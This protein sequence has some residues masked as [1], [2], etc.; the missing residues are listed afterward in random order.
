MSSAAVTPPS[1]PRQSIRK[2]LLGTGLG[3]ALEWYDWNVYTAM[4]AFLAAHLFD[5]SDPTSAVLSTL[6]VFA[7]GFLARPLGGFLF[8][9]VGDRKGRKFSLMLSVAAA[10]VGS[11]LIGL[12]PE[13]DT[14]GVVA[15]IWLLCARL[16]QG[17]AHGGELPSAQTYLV[18]E[19]PRERRGLW[20]SWIYVSGTAGNMIA[21]AVGALLATVLSRDQM[22]GFGWRIPF[23]LGAAFGLYA[24]YMR[25]GMI[26]SETF[27]ADVAQTDE[28]KIPLLKDI[29]AHW[30]QA[31]QVILMTSGGTVAY[32]AW[33]VNAPAYA[34]NQLKIPAAPA[35]WVGVAANLIFVALLPVYGW[36]SDRI[37][38]KKVALFSVLG[39][40]ALFIPMNAVLSNTPLSLFIAMGTMMITLSAYSAIAPAMYAEMFPTRVRTAGVGV[41]Y[42]I[43]IA[44]FGGTAPLI[45]QALVGRYPDQ[46]LL[47]PIYAI[48]LLL[49]SAGTILSLRETRG[50][51]LSSDVG[52]RA[53][54]D[55]PAL[56]P[57][58]RSPSR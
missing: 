52:S 20:S 55:D 43:C 48:A 38:R 58:R 5:R 57:S 33:A 22:S 1:A 25:K 4:S 49:V 39:S 13:F 50:I 56:R 34:Q 11:L 6:A 30:R 51:D 53:A 27:V 18:E 24:L 17:L 44:L 29:A 3:N 8:G 19:A 12:A 35:L 21:L 32:Y 36:L 40:A 2:T 10:S 31:L 42:S 14:V 37:G 41:P 15:S 47:F 28:P 54:R 46:K 23:L 26:E 16:L 7:V 45:Q 9:W